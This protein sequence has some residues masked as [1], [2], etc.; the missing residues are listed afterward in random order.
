MVAF[1]LQQQIDDLKERLAAANADAA[2][3]EGVLQGALDSSIIRR[4]MSPEFRDECLNRCKTHRARV[5]IE[6][7]RENTE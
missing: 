5:A 4:A 7:E 2:S 3:L 6:K 1:I